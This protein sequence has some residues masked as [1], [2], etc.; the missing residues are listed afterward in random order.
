[1]PPNVTNKTLFI[2]SENNW[3]TSNSSQY[4]YKADDKKI[5]KIVNETGK[6][7]V[8]ISNNVVNTV[9]SKPSE[10]RIEIS[11]DVDK[12][13]KVT[14]VKPQ[15]QV[16]GNKT[17]SSI[18]D[19][20]K[21]MSEV[22]D[23]SRENAT[24]IRLNTN[25]FTDIDLNKEMDIA[26]EDTDS[27]N[28]TSQDKQCITCD[29]HILRFSLAVIIIDWL[30]VVIGIVYFCNFVINRFSSITSKLLLINA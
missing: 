29:I 4:Q 12:V 18:N 21:D 8:N 22:R 7:P 20:S 5:N 1:M 24:E 17:F 16:T 19:G 25:E 26:K 6:M 11:E 10:K 23:A 3:I 9:T 30:F 28:T 15:T 2:H 27:S 13:N 14:S